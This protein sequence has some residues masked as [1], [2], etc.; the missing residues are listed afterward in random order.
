MSD[1]VDYS[2]IIDKNGKRRK[3]YDEKDVEKKGSTT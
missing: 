3:K 1:S 2:Y